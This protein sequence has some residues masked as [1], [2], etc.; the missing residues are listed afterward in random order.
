MKIAIIT[1]MEK[2]LAPIY[3]QLGHAIG[4]ETIGGITIYRF[5][6]IQQMIWSVK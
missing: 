2:E 5:Y 4:N 3:N 6:I 1:A